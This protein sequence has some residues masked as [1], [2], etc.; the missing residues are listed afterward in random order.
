M[1]EK[2]TKENV[3]S[4]EIHILFQIKVTYEI[5]NLNAKHKLTYFLHT[6]YLGFFFFF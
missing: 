6:G 4:A 2:K 3:M 1:V 5:V